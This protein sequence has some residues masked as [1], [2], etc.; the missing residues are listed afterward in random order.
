MELGKEIGRCGLAT[1]A[2]TAPQTASDGRSAAATD[3]QKVRTNKKKNETNKQTKKNS[4]RLA[5]RPFHVTSATRKRLSGNGTIER[6]IRKKKKKANIRKKTE[7][8]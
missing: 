6:S 4:N 1:A 7:L 8:S 3:H 2:E 5:S